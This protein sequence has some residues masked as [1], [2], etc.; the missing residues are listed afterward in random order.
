MRAPCALT[1]FMECLSCASK[2]GSPDLCASCLHNR[3]ALDRAER[4]NRAA[5]EALRIARGYMPNPMGGGP[6]IG[7]RDSILVDRAILEVT[8]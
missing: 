5:R 4:V 6:A 7:V 3:A 1:G 8:T 2:P